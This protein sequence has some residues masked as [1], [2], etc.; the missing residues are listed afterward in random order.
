MASSQTPAASSSR[1]A[2]A[3][4]FYDDFSR[5]ATHIEQAIQ[6]AKDADEL[7]APLSRISQMRTSVTENHD[8]LPAYDRNTYE[9]VGVPSLHLIGTRI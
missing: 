3:A 5:S 1:A 7:T 4:A 2:Q 6:Q 8:L 9:S